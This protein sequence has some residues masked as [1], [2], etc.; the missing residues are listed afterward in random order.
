[1]QMIMVT[2]QVTVQVTEVV[3]EVVTYGKNQSFKKFKISKMR[4]QLILVALALAL[5]QITSKFS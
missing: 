5:F 4:F 2:V 1:M 3:T